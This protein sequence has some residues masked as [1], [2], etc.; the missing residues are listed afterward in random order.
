MRTTSPWPKPFAA[1]GWQVAVSI[2]GS[3]PAHCELCDFS[4][5][6]EKSQRGNPASSG[7]DGGI[8]WTRFTLLDAVGNLRSPKRTFSA[9]G[10]RTEERSSCSSVTPAASTRERRRSEEHTSELQS[11]Q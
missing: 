4:V 8:S 2:S 10:L 11:R 3:G 1:A 5:E 9:K 6:F 7:G